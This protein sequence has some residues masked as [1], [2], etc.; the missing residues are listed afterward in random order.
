MGEG[1][2]AEGAGAAN[3]QR[4]R[5]LIPAGCRGQQDQRNVEVEVAVVAAVVAAAGGGAAGRS[6]E[7]WSELR[8][9]SERESVIRQ[10]QP[11]A[12]A[13]QVVKPTPGFY[14]GGGGG[15]GGCPTSGGVRNNG[16]V[17]RSDS[18]QSAAINAVIHFYC[19][20]RGAAAGGA[21]VA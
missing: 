21:D 18:L 4:S 1:R 8:S 6:L 7:R 17:I 2:Q 19:F 11:R 10:T 12:T 13:A 3:Q 15:G 9:V 20:Q 5:R 14:G 16:G